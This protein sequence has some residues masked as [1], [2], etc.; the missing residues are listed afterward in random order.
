MDLADCYAAYR[1]RELN[2]STAL[3]CQVGRQPG[4]ILKVDRMEPL[5]SANY[6]VTLGN[7]WAVTSTLPS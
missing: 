2:S 4:A 5:P 6:W 1:Q 7:R 3:L